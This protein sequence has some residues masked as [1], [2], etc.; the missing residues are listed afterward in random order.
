MKFGIV[1]V[2]M[3]GNIMVKLGYFSF[4]NF[5]NILICFL[6]STPQV[7]GDENISRNVSHRAF[8]KS[9]NI[10]LK[11]YV[12]LRSPQYC[13][14][15][16]SDYEPATLNW[17]IYRFWCKPKTVYT[18]TRLC[19]WHQIVWIM[20]FLLNRVLPKY[21]RTLN[22]HTINKWLTITMLDYWFD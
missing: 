3:K 2:L 19:L 17:L 6:A 5:W 1:I 15:N 18:L 9:R 22:L 12:D 10:S 8:W 20:L 4:F 7:K 13:A 11:A 16:N 21:R 14:I